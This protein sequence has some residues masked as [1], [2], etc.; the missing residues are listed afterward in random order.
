MVSVNFTPCLCSN[1]VGFTGSEGGGEGRWGPDPPQAD[2]PYSLM[3][4]FVIW[5]F[6]PL[7]QPTNTTALYLVASKQ[8]K[9]DRENVVCSGELQAQSLSAGE[10]TQQNWKLNCVVCV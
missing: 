7:N 8:V 3:I 6:S 5:H 2:S 1:A 9:L 10:M 4:Y